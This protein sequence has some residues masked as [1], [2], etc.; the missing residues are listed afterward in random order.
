MVS[1]VIVHSICNLDATQIAVGESKG[2]RVE[3]KYSDDDG[4]PQSLKTVSKGENIVAYFIQYFLLIFADG[5]LVLL[6][7]WWLMAVWMAM[8]WMCVVSLHWV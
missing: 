4:R 7:M 2:G 1:L 6:C 8:P 3:E 5:R